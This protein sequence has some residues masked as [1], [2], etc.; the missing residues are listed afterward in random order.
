MWSRVRAR[1]PHTLGAFSLIE[2]SMVL[3]IMG[4]ILSFSL[5]YLTNHLVFERQ[6]QTSANFEEITHALALF[7]MQ[8]GRLP[9]PSSPTSSENRGQEDASLSGGQAGIIPFKT[10]G[11]SQ[12]SAKDGYNHWIS[13]IPHP[14]L[15]DE[16][17]L[18]RSPFGDEATS[19]CAVPL[20]PSF[21]LLDDRN[22][23]IAG[24]EDMQPAYMLISHGK[25]GGDFLE[26]GSMRILGHQHPC[27]NENTNGDMVFRESL[28]KECDDKVFWK[29]R[30][31]LLAVYAKSPCPVLGD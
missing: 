3:L 16:T 1:I 27:K 21:Q 25:G 30:Q 12:V 17:T 15:T 24:E 6:K 19:F 26:S 10:L 14:A 31:I 4:V 22:A 8:T 18:S 7:V 11:L 20:E 23:N 29:N 28:S 13:Y 5:P 2:M 9:Y